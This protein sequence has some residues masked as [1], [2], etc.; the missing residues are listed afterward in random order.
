MFRPE[1]VPFHR[2]LQSTCF[3]LTPQQR[4]HRIN[5]IPDCPDIT[6]SVWLRHCRKHVHRLS[7]R[8]HELSVGHER[9]IH[10]MAQRMERQSLRGTVQG[11]QNIE[12][13]S[14]IN[15]GLSFGDWT[16]LTSCSTQRHRTDIMRKTGEGYAGTLQ[17]DWRSYA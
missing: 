12:N 17:D 3:Q 7:R 8:A 1:F 6:D 4:L 9:T 13:S 14:S 16:S 10:T 5:P 15:G 2:R 11:L